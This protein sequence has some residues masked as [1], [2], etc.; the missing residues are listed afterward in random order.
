VRSTRG[1][2]RGI[3]AALT[4]F[5]LAVSALPA[6]AFA[7][8]PEEGDLWG[9]VSYGDGSGLAGAGEVEVEAKGSGSSAVVVT[10]ETEAD[11]RFV[12]SDLPAGSYELK[13]TPD[14]TQHQVTW[15]RTSTIGEPR[16]RVSVPVTSAPLAMSLLPNGSVSGRVALGSPGNWAGA[17]EV[18][19]T[20]SECEL[21]YYHPE[22]GRC[23]AFKAYTG[24]TA[25]DGT[26]RVE[27]LEDGYFLL[28]YEYLG[29]E[30]YTRL[31]D[32][33]HFAFRLTRAAGFHVTGHDALV[34]VGAGLSGVITL[35]GAPA[36][37]EDVEISLLGY[38]GQ[39]TYVIDP[40]E[41]GAY[42]FDRLNGR[43]DLRVTYVGNEDFL[44]QTVS[45]IHVTPGEV[46]DLD[47]DLLSGGR[48]SGRVT[49]S[50]GAGLGDRYV[51]LSRERDY[52]W[53]KA[54]EEY[55]SLHLPDDGV[56][57][58]ASLPAGTYQVRVS[59]GSCW[60]NQVCYV[61]ARWRDPVNGDY[62]ITLDEYEVRDDL[63]VTLYR[64]V[65][66]VG[67]VTCG[68]CSETYGTTF[69]LR[70]LDEFTGAWVPQIRN[71][72]TGFTLPLRHLEPGVYQ[73]T[74]GGGYGIARWGSGPLTLDED[75]T[76]DLGEVELERANFLVR[77]SNGTL[78]RYP[79]VNGR[80]GS[81]EKLSTIYGQYTKVVDAGDVD[82][83]GF[84]D[85]Y[86]VDKAGVLFVRPGNADG[87]FGAATR[88]S[89]GWGGYKFVLGFPDLTGDGHPDIVAQG[90]TGALYLFPGDGDRG[91]GERR[92]IGSATQWKGYNYLAVY[93]NDLIA[94]GSS[95]KTY[96]F[97]PDVGGTGFDNRNLMTSKWSTATQILSVGGFDGDGWGDVVVR[98]SAGSI[99]LWRGGGS[100]WANPVTLATN[101]SGRL[102]I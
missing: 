79:A 16:D 96:V 25:D 22:S 8:E 58:F 78:Y 53:Y 52:G 30:D 27:G 41:P 99:Q 28:S 93:G 60:P 81:A 47:V 49:D 50:S 17:G 18:R 55:T 83:D 101:W 57:S 46:H 23:A 13:F 73:L 48:L 2:V 38:P 56:W 77:T 12:F 54:F 91:L 72:S 34:P 89:S 51:V 1:I 80:L 19:V 39:R 11:G 68:F 88:V 3:F 61:E 102:L 62:S 9:Y 14:S 69:G 44:S 20:A 7:A 4:S 66:I 6:V 35:D 40:D 59:V 85:L 70:R 95:G 24:L 29:S 98:T 76:L 32:D 26:Y 94:R 100:S 10:V 43:Y 75:E 21:D 82:H 5:V 64:E 31:E 87:K 15:W 63:D 33:G 92:S 36:Q 42:S 45:S 84:A 67:E 90:N 71:G 37:A 74:T 86:V 65:R 97:S